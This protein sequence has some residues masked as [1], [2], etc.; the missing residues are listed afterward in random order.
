MG[1]GDDGR[2]QRRRTALEPPQFGADGAPLPALQGVGAL[3]KWA[4]PDS[5]A[6][7][8]T[9][10]DT[11]RAIVALVADDVTALFPTNPPGL[12]LGMLDASRA[13]RFADVAVAVARDEYGLLY[14]DDGLI[15]LQQTNT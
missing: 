10:D 15:I 8:A 13:T 2:R 1:D 11:V 6:A 9:L 3:A 7:R 12:L 14:G 5:D 4:D